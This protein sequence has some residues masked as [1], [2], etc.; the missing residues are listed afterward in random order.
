MLVSKFDKLA[1]PVLELV[2]FLLQLEDSRYVKASVD[3]CYTN[4][5]IRQERFKMLND[6]IFSHV[7]RQPASKESK[8]ACGDPTLINGLMDSVNLPRDPNLGM[9]EDKV[10]QNDMQRNINAD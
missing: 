3:P 4:S 9:N 7:R 6:L 10:Q 1:L 5:S 2:I 8:V